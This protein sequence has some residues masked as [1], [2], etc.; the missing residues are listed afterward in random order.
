MQIDTLSWQEGAE[1]V[2]WVS[3]TGMEY[4]M[5]P[6]DSRTARGTTITLYIADDSKE[7]LEAYRLREILNKYCSFL[8]VGN[9]FR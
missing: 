9:L 6:S 1:P 2:R 5:E 8:P 7:F 3:E 4:N